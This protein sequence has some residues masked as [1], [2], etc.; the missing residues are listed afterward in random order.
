MEADFDRLRGWI[1]RTEAR[2]DLLTPRLAEAFDATLDEPP[3]AY[4]SGDTAPL[5]IHWCLGNP[6]VRASG[7]GRDGHPKREGFMPPVPLPRR[8]WAAGKLTFAA[9]LLVGL[10]VTR[11][12]TIAA[13]DRKQGRTGP[14]FFLELDHLYLQE[15][16][17]CVTERQTLVYREDPKPGGATAE[18]GATARSAGGAHRPDPHARRGDAVP[19]LGPDLQ[20]PPHPL[21]PRL[22]PRGR[23]LSRARRARPA[24]R[25]LPDARLR[26]GAAG[27]PARGAVLPRPV[28]KLRRAAAVGHAVGGSAASFAPAPRAR[29]VP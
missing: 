12:T 28:A 25:H 1:G 5:G 20:R 27:A 7:L 9:P 16:V 8:M 4:E 21:R 13:I 22:C 14:L 6:A 11:Q 17:T 18:A 23:G 15:G 29:A 10:N 26:R 24:D 3:R 19:L 2:A